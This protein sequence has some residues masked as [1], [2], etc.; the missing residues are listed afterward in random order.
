MLIK[1]FFASILTILVFAASSQAAT[2]YVAQ[3]AQVAAASDS[4]AGT[5][6][7]APWVTIAKVAAT[8][9]S[10]DTVYF[11]SASTWTGATP[12]LT[13]T[14]G[15]K[16]Y[17]ASWGGGTKAKFTATTAESSIGVV[18]LV[19]SN[20]I[21][22]GFEIDGGGLYTGGIG[23]GYG[24]AANIDNIIINNCEVHHTG[25]VSEPEDSYWYYGIH[26]CSLV[27]YKISN[28]QVTNCKVYDVGH[29]GIQFYSQYNSEGFGRIEDCLARSNE[30]YNTG[31]SG[32]REAPLG[33]SNNSLNI[34]LEYNYLHDV[35]EGGLQIVEYNCDHP[36]G[37]QIDNAIVRYNLL[38]NTAGITFNTFTGNKGFKGYG[39]IYGNI[40]YGGGLSIVYTDFHS[41]SWKIYNNIFEVDYS[42]GTPSSY[43]L[44][45][46][47]NSLGNAENIEL[48]NN[49]FINKGLYV[50]RDLSNSMS[51][52]KHGNNLFFRR[53]STSNLITTSSL[54]DA[55]AVSATSVSVTNTS[56]NTYFT[57]SGGTDW[58]AIFAANDCVQ[59]SGFA[60][61]EFNDR[62]FKILEVTADQIKIYNVQYG[63]DGNTETATVTGQKWVTTSYSAAQVAEG[64]YDTNPQ[65]TDPLFTG[66]DLPTGFA[67]NRP[68]TDYFLPQTTSLAFR[69]GTPTLKPA[70]DIRG[71]P[72]S[73][74]APAIGAYER[75]FGNVANIGKAGA[76]ATSGAGASATIGN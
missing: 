56:G 69:N 19:A 14:A 28:V 9:T 44:N 39:A 41:S 20:I 29:E 62:R 10:G 13:G 30:I 53:D 38:V 3:T 54:S 76:T 32:Q 49:I 40:S 57:K 43:A 31:V 23:T 35:P 8:A 60:N 64:L 24:V 22:D 52:I 59:W 27:G 68:N 36:N 34:T 61:D 67:N 72:Y 47:Y 66:G 74:S 42:A 12:I 45:I 15:V 33:I 73:A 6:P 58:T 4:N 18:R 25:S 48:Y 26:V 51:S 37:G 11:H 65:T 46:M 17:G 21:F 70:V 63:A 75:L 5:D 50:V 55:N 7:V 16:Y 71:Y 2:Y 1:R